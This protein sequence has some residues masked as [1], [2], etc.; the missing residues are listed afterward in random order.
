MT[1]VI[2][3]KSKTTVATT[4]SYGELLEEHLANLSEE[5]KN[6]KVYT[7]LVVLDTDN[8]VG[9]QNLIPVNQF[10][11]VGIIECLKALLIDDACYN[12]K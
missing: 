12:E 11:L 4:Y 1:K 8:G 5:E 10:T 9:Y 6:L 2:D 7:A 3:I